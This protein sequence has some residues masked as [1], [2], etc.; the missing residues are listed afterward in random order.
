[1]KGQSHIII[2]SCTSGPFFIYFYLLCTYSGRRQKKSRRVVRA[3][4]GVWF[5]SLF[6][7]V[8][9]RPMNE[10]DAGTLQH[11]S[12]QGAL[13]RI[14]LFNLAHLKSS[15]SAHATHRLLF[16]CNRNRIEFVSSHSRKGNLG[17]EWD[18]GVE[19]ANKPAIW[20]ANQALLTSEGGLSSFND[21][22]QHTQ[23]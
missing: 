14:P 20:K 23:M 13:W 18:R 9:S 17:L 8:L 12:K 10:R 11:C 22:L 1:M 6:N 15:S 5:H 19:E 7:C 21:E 4:F 3:W 2:G 16:S